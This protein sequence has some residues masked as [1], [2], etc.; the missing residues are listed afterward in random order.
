MLKL[1]EGWLTVFLACALMLV[2]AAGVEACQWADGLW[3]A[4]CTGLLGVLAGLALAKSH[5][6]G[7]TAALFATVYGIFCVGFFSSFLLTGDWHV[8]SVGVA[9]RMGTF[10]L[11]LIL[12]GTSSDALPFPVLISSLFWLM[13]VSGAWM[14]FRRNAVWPA[15]LPGGLMLVIN[16]YYYQ[17]PA[18]LNVHVMLY[19]LAALLLLGQTSLLARERE[20]RRTGVIFNPDIR[21]D[22][23]RAGVA[24]AFTGVLVAWVAPSISTPPEVASAWQQVNGYWSNVRE[25]WMRMFTAVRGSGQLATDFYGNSLALG[26]PVHLSDTPLM[27][28]AVGLVGGETEA[29]PETP[30]RYYWRAEAFER[31]ENGQWLL[32]NTDFK[33]MSPDA[34]NLRLPLYR[35]R[36]DVS[37]AITMRVFSTSRLYVVGQ[38]R[39]VAL[40]N[41]NAAIY[42]VI[43]TPDGSADV[44]TVRAR[45]VLVGKE[46]TYR[47]VGSLS[48][49]DVDSLR[50]AGTEYPLWVASRFLQLP[51]EITDRTRQL[52]RQIADRATANNPYDRAQAVTDWLRTNITYNQLI[53]APPAGVEPVDWFLFTSRQGYCNYYASAEVVL[54]RSLGIPAR[55]AA[56]F[57]EGDYDGASSSPAISVYRVKEKQAHAWVEVFFPTYGWVEFEPTVSEAPLVRPARPV[58]PPV[59]PLGTAPAPAPTVS[60]Q[61]TE[62]PWEQ[63]LNPLVRGI[64]WGQVGWVTVI[65]LG[66]AAGLIALSLGLLLRRGLLGWESLGQLGAWAMRVRRQAM[67]SAIGAVYLRLER[68]ARWLSLPLQLSQAV[69]PARPGVETITAQYVQEK[70]SQRSAD[71][72]AARAAWLDIRFKV[73]REGLRR[74]FHRVEKVDRVNGREIHPN[75]GT[76]QNP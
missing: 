20:W 18:N 55:L 68:A 57:S 21:L 74:F 43:I 70:Y 71:A 33:E 42:S 17:G 6:K 56:G 50:Q 23:L 37:A 41:N 46:R 2:S 9:D 26:G 35:L 59:G 60:P 27:D 51:P 30:P 13:G 64:D 47:V 3:T 31:Y 73:W 48:V 10:F 34:P 1:E 53:D 65:V 19:V 52:A 49:A 24:V 44:A 69:P 45:N 11:R 58:R 66:L 36:R 76:P 54:L 40:L 28:V 22:F 62:E 7:L 8:R 67:P 4:W 12:G 63:G 75:S 5:L 72:E 32:G 16:A 38:P 15:I 25:T 29:N 14:L 39:L 61:K